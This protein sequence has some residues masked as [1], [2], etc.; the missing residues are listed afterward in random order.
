MIVIPTTITRFAIPALLSAAL[1][2]GAPRAAR[3]A[4]TISEQD[5]HAIGVQAY[6]YFYS[7]DHNGPD[8]EAAHQRRQAR[9]H[10]RADEH[11]RQ[12]LRHTPRR[13]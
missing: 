6:L 8:A 3:A 12:H 7:L 13:T 1:S 5:A 4:E 9:R 10:L 11:V 2:G